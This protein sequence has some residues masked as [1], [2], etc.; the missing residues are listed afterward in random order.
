MNPNLIALMVVLL[1]GET[2][3]ATGQSPATNE[4]V[5]AEVEI[6]DKGELA[7]ISVYL[8]N[9]S[10]EAKL[11]Y[12]GR[13]AEC[14][15]EFQAVDLDMV[16]TNGSRVGGGRLAVPELTFGSLTFAAPVLSGGSSLLCHYG[17]PTLIE[18]RPHDR[19]L[20]C[21]FS[22]PVLYVRKEFVSGNIQFPSYSD[23]KGSVASLHVPITKCER[24]K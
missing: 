1:A 24:K 14:T 2:V 21:K 16:A 17:G 15:F 7:R 9:K 4:P 19:L 8:L 22:V 23:S 3:L 13:Y 12:T 6:Q 5:V 18:L 20:Y 10:G 11:L